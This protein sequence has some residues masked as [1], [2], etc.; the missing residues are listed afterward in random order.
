MLSRILR[1]SHP[2]FAEA[3]HASPPLTGFTL[4]WVKLRTKLEI[5]KLEDSRDRNN[6]QTVDFSNPSSR[7]GQILVELT[8][9]AFPPGSLTPICL[10]SAARDGK[11]LTRRCDKLNNV[12]DSDLCR[13]F[14]AKLRRNV[15]HPS[16]MNKRVS[17]VPTQQ[18]LNFELL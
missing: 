11:E 13:D 6:P 7:T 9:R 18:A 1:R 17:R 16:R 3:L 5:S 12:G 8:D 2:F 10:A 4:R 15:N 14:G